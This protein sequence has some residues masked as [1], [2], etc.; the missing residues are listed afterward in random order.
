MSQLGR[1]EDPKPPSLSI[2]FDLSP[3]FSGGCVEGD[4]L[5]SRLIV[6]V[7]FSVLHV[8]RRSAHAQIRTLVIQLVRVDVVYGSGSIHNSQD[9]TM[10]RDDC[11]CS[12]FWIDGGSDRISFT[13]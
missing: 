6:A 10:H 13:V 8:L 5:E 9:I 2:T 7:T 11:L 12:I 3:P 4:T 1:F